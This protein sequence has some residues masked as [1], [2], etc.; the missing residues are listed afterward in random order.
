MFRLLGKSNKKTRRR[1]SMSTDLRDLNPE[2]VIAR[3]EVF[4]KDKMSE[5]A[6]ARNISFCH[7]FLKALN[8]PL[9]EIT[10]NDA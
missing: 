7:K 5:A 2:T 3:Y 1:L 4:L 8:K 10:M 6:I 9:S